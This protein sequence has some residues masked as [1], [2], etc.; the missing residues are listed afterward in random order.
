MCMYVY[1]SRCVCLVRRYLQWTILFVV[2]TV[3]FIVWTNEWKER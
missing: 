2:D 3:S 1:I